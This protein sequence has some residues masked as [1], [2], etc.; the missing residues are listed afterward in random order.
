MHAILAP[1]RYRYHSSSETRWV[2]V[3]SE[4]SNAS[5]RLASELIQLVRQ[6]LLTTPPQSVLDPLRDFCQIKFEDC[7]TDMA[8]SAAEDRGWD[9]LRLADP[10]TPLL[11]LIY[12]NTPLLTTLLELLLAIPPQNEKASS[13]SSS[14]VVAKEASLMLDLFSNFVH[15]LDAHCN[16]HSCFIRPI[17]HVL[18]RWPEEVPVSK[19]F[20]VLVGKITME[21]KQRRDSEQLLGFVRSSGARLVFECLAGTCRQLRPSPDT[22]SAESVTKLGDKDL[23]KP[24]R[25]GSPLVNFLPL[26]SIKVSP[27]RTSARDLQ[28]S[29]QPLQPSRT[30]TFHHTFRPSETWLTL[31]VTLP[32]PILLHS[33]QLH[34]PLGLVQNGPSSITL[35]CSRQ[36]SSSAAIAV[37]PPLE[38]SGLSSVRIDLPRPPVVQ[39]V[40]LHLRR[41]VLADSISLSH[42]H[43]LGLGYGAQQQVATAGEEEASLHNGDRPHPR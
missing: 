31:T 20:V 14:S 38:T 29:S 27:S 39:E 13:L 17:L 23:P 9:V 35:E 32:Y 34:Q 36:H 5:S 18:S 7:S 3:H 42:L 6:V 30:S 24:F 11:C 8:P 26:A 28:M 33:M 43:L 15:Y 40:V 19:T 16:E 22:T 12:A 4:Q 21:L 2:P 10:S 25:E 41:P 1:P 37:A